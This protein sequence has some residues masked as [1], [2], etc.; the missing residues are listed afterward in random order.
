MFVPQANS[1][2]VFARSRRVL[3]FAIVLA[4]LALSAC[5]HVDVGPVPQRTCPPY[6][7]ANR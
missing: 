6:C 2:A 5:G 1:P 3:P 4:S 7:H